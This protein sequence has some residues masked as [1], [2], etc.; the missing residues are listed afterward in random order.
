MDFIQL[1]TVSRKLWTGNADGRLPPITGSG[2]SFSFLF[3]FFPPWVFQNGTG[4]GGRTDEVNGPVVRGSTLDRTDLFGGESRVDGAEL[5]VG[6]DMKV[7]G[8]FFFVFCFV[9]RT[10]R[11]RNGREKKEKKKKHSQ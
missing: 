4:A 8:T 11:E 5:D 1:Y 2:T 3:S 6:C 7:S 9:W 10:E